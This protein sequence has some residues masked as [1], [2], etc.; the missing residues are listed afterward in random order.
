MDKE[1]LVLSLIRDDL[2]NTK[3][4]YGLSDLGINADGYLLHLSTT[5]FELMGFDEK[6]RS[7]ELTERYIELTQQM[8]SIDAEEMHEQL[9]DMAK[10]VHAELLA[11][12]S[13]QI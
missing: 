3:L 11:I 6:Q 1:K 8:K 13:G 10:S 2:I 5:I 7:D 12:K 4:V 9:A